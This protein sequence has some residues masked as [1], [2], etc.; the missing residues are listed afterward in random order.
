VHESK[1]KEEVSDLTQPFVPYGV[2]SPRFSF[3]GVNGVIVDTETDVLEMLSE[4]Y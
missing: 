1:S 4:V 3:L 2:E